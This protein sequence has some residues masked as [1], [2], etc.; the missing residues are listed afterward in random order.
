MP[1]AHASEVESAL[2]DERTSLPGDGFGEG[3]AAQLEP[4][5]W[6][7]S[8]RDRPPE[9]NCSPTAHPS[10]ALEKLTP[11]RAWK[12]FTCGPGTWVQ[13]LPSHRTTSV[14]SRPAWST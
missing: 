2:T 12:S 9:G 14:C 13:V 3:I 4:F 11:Y 7:T 1:T 8:V 6:A 10:S 5:Q